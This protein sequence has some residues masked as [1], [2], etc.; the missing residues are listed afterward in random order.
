MAPPVDPAATTRVLT[1]RARTHQGDMT[2]G[3][4]AQ[5]RAEIRARLGLSARARIYFAGEQPLLFGGPLKVLGKLLALK[6]LKRQD[7]EAQTVFAVI[8]SD[9][10][11]SNRDC[12]R[13][14]LPRPSPGGWRGLHRR[15]FRA[16][17]PCFGAL[18]PAGR[19]HR[20]ARSIAADYGQDDFP[21]WLGSGL[22]QPVLGQANGA[23]LAGIA[24]ALDLTPDLWIED[25]QIE[26]LYAEPDI[27]LLG[28]LLQKWPALEA[29]LAPSRRGLAPFWL[30]PA[31]DIR[32]DL[33]YHDGRLWGTTGPVDLDRLAEESAA[34]RWRLALRAA[35]RIWALSVWIDAQVTGSGSAYNAAVEAAGAAC[36]QPVA[37]RWRWPA[38]DCP[39][40][41]PPFGAATTPD[42]PPAGMLD[43]LLTTDRGAIARA[44]AACAALPAF[45]SET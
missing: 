30:I 43:H 34:D 31:G 13:V 4:W 5:A 18:L 26:R 23:F 19:L 2:R 28:R 15:V 42:R 37:P 33:A 17:M 11:R 22:D 12:H 41:P 9:A 3:I 24:A 45:S 21:D 29:A 20:L 6:H 7:P 10:A 44:L 1:A 39:G 32:A 16:G 14:F 8:S 36:G 25:W 38:N 27:G 35:P 40:G